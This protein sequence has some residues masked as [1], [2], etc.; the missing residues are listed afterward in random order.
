MC[1]LAVLAVCKTCE[2]DP[3]FLDVVQVD[4]PWCLMFT[5]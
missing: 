2:E 3:Q 4:V 5:S 1:V